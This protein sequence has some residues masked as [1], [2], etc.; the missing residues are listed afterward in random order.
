MDAGW[1]EA[2]AA[3]ISTLRHLAA[4]A[5][6][7]FC[8]MAACVDARVSLHDIG[9]MLA[10]DSPPAAEL[11]RL[12]QARAERGTG[13]E[14]PYAWPEGPAW[15]AAHLP[16]RYAM[17]GTGPHAAWVLSAVRAPALLALEDRSAAMLRLVP[18]E[19][20]LAE[21]DRLLPAG[22]V[23]P[24]GAAR[25]EVFIFEY[26]AGR[27]VGQVV[28]TRSSRIIVR[29]SNLGLEHDEAYDR[30]TIGLAPEAGA[31]LVAGF[32]AVPVADLDREARRAFS[33]ARAWRE[34]GLR[35]VH[36]ELAGYDTTAMVETV[37]DAARGTASS[38][39][40]SHSEFLW[41]RGRSADLGGAMAALGEAHG[42]D[43][44]CVHADHWA[45]AV[46]RC[47]PERERRALLL[48]CLLAG[49]RAAAGRPVP[50]RALAPEARF[51]TLP[52]A[53]LARHGAWS[54]VAVAAP[55]LQHPATTLG[56]GDTFTAGCLL[57]LGARTGAA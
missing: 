54:F 3:V 29:F 55:H 50:P 33:L 26:T 22:A 35:T 49:A 18:P 23:P 37:L 30:L 44:V 51:E 48:G 4:Q 2:Y 31:G 6:L 39:G 42:M 9:P 21:G 56:L 17:G 19:I 15:I 40:M 46:T 52:F 20:L 14:L 5:P 38:I 43:R 10:A 45:A 28:P 13:G 8:G 27:P 57:A 7:T 53:P 24:R 36:L 34:A 16:V 47:D 25:P 32:S 41:L 1:A 11:A 12:L